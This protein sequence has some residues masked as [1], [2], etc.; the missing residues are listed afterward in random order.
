MAVFIHFM[1]SVTDTAPPGPANCGMEASSALTTRSEG[2]ES[3]LPWCSTRPVRA[4]VVVFIVWV[5]VRADQLFNRVL[6][7]VL[8]SVFHGGLF[9]L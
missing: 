2:L 5:Q 7:V 9:P 8:E 4:A 6:E 3:A 1:K